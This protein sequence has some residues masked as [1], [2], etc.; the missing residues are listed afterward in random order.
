MCIR[1]RPQVEELFKE[2]D[3]FKLRTLLGHLTV[4]RKIHCIKLWLENLE[5][6]WYFEDIL[7]ATERLE[8]D[9]A[10]KKEL[11]ELILSKV[12]SFPGSF[13]ARDTII[14]SAKSELRNLSLESGRAARAAGPP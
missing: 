13:K 14:K 4:P 7:K 9:V 12:N 6:S 10:T 1:D 5:Y 8:T 3:G 2:G 11:L